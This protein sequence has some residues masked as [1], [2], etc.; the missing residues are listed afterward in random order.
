MDFELAEE[1]RMLAQLVA[2]FVADHLLPLEPEVLARE[3]AGVGAYI[4]AEERRALDATSRELGLWG[5]DAPES[6]GGMDLPAVALV[7]VNEHIGKSMVPYVLPPDSPNLR[8]LL[9]RGSFYV[10][11]GLFA[12][13]ALQ[14]AGFNLTVLLGAAGILSIGGRSREI[15]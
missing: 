1:Y 12:L 9:P 6:M 5:L 7:A 8:M 14:Q 3:A 4:T 2:N 10:V 15:K 11:F 13:M